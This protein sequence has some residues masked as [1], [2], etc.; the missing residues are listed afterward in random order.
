LH[1]TLCL[2]AYRNIDFELGDDAA[3]VDAGALEFF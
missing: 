1:A 2:C 3:D